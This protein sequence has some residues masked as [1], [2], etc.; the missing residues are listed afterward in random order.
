MQP[1]RQK[2]LILQYAVLSNAGL[3]FYAF[4]AILTWNQY[5]K[6]STLLRTHSTSSGIYTISL[7]E[8]H[9]QEVATDT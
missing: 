6:C 5:D 9:Y 2:A 7:N 8:K 4:G 1:L 3:P